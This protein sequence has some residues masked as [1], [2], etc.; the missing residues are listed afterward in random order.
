MLQLNNL[1]VTVGQNT[2]LALHVL[3]D[4]KLQVS[5]G[6]FVII[7]GG[8]GCGK[9]TL[10]NTVAGHIRPDSGQIIIDN[11]DVTQQGTQQRVKSVSLVMQDPRL[12]TISNMTIAENLNLAY[13][14]GSR[15]GL[16]L[17]NQ[18]QRRDLFVQKLSMLNMGLEKRLDYLVGNLSGGQ[19]QA[20]SLIMAIVADYKILL[21]DEITAAL[22]PGMAE[23]VMGIA[24]RII[25]EDKRAAI[26]ITHNMQH[27]LRYGAK[28]LLMQDGKIVREYNYAA[29]NDLNPVSLAAAIGGMY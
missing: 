8:N 29:K 2:P 6:E 7:V 18:K 20:L 16:F 12:G 28:T 5:A 1:N 3:K 10:L 21:M 25:A 15:R 13:L 27:A 24:A 19:R 17:H 26:M 14:R 9:S 11:C 23:N 22:D 4:F